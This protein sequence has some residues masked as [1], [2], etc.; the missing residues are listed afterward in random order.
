MEA[1]LWNDIQVSFVSECLL[2]CVELKRILIYSA[3]LKKP[4]ITTSRLCQSLQYNQ[5][6][7]LLF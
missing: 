7:R 6:N 1:T 4:L 3:I 5:Q 2:T